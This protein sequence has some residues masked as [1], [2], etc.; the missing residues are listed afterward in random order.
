MLRHNIAINHLTNVTVIDAAV[1][2]VTGYASFA[3][4]KDTAL[5]SL[6]DIERNDQQIAEWQKVRTIRLD[7]AVT[8]YAIP[9]VTFVKMDVEGAEKLALGGALKLLSSATAPFAI[10]FEAFDQ[11]TRAFG[12]T[13]RELLEELRRLGF[14][15]CGFDRTLTLRPLEQ[16]GPEVG[17]SIYNF[18]AYKRDS[19]RPRQ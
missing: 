3:E 12:Y 16:L 7:D 13:A 2:D 10:L 15:L 14:S 4:A 6:A 9:R 17:T 18:V 5:S 19:S 1:S 11:N 8:Q